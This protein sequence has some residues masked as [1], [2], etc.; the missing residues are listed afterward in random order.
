MEESANELINMLCD[1]GPDS[2]DEDDDD[3]DDDDKDEDGRN[4]FLL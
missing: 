4:I 3:L 1:T 2:Q